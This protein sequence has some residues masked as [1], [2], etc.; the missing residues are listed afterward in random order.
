MMSR[1]L[2]QPFIDVHEY[3]NTWLEK[4]LTDGFGHLCEHLW[5]VQPEQQNC[6]L[7][8][9]PVHLKNQ[10]LSVPGVSQDILVVFVRLNVIN[11][12]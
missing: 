10:E 8:T 4:D 11:N 1:S 3:L 6:E 9:L 5:S 7:K 2:G 12:E